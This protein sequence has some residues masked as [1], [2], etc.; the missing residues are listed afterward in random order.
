MTPGIGKLKRHISYQVLSKIQTKVFSLAQLQ[1][2]NLI[3][4]NFIF[5]RAVAF[6][7]PKTADRFTDCMLQRRF[8]LFSTVQKPEISQR[9]KAINN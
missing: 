5:F 8:E 1:M 7:E 4:N 3:Q 6:L 2:R 9:M